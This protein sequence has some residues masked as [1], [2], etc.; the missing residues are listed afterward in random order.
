MVRSIK[1]FERKIIMLGSN[2]PAI[3]GFHA[4]F[5]W[6]DRWGCESIQIYI[7]LSR[8]WDVPELAKDEIDKFKSAWKK[9][10]I[11]QVVAHV[12]YLVNLASP[13]EELREKSINRLIIEISRAEKF[14][15]PFLV[16]HPGSYGSSTRTKGIKR[17]IQ[18][19]DAIHDEV[20]KTSVKVLIETMAGQGTM[21]G[22]SFEE[23]AEILESVANPEDLGVCFDTAHVF[24]ADYDI[25]GY[26]GYKKII[27]EFDEI[28][29]LDKIAVFHINGSKTKLGSRSDRHACIDE[30]ELGLQIFHA[31][32]QDKRFLGIPKILEIPERD[33][34]SKD[35]LGLLNKIKNISE[36]LP[37][38]KYAPTQL[39]L[40]KEVK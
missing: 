24:I 35:N 19:L 8:R 15:V 11:K 21:I 4:G 10:S 34:K 17:I 22:S 33:K 3:G 20:K 1:D 36:P 30:G 38:E 6:G 26:R 18:A 14:G 31:L 13:D 39:K 37:D 7:T 16:L 27:K 28:V 29:S 32:L 12:P 23:I 40:V 25:R 2:V 9:S 5:E